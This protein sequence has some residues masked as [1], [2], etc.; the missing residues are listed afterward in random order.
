VTVDIQYEFGLVKFLLNR[1]GTIPSPALLN[2]NHERLVA[3]LEALEERIG[4]PVVRFKTG[5]SKENLAR[6]F[7]DEA[8]ATGRPGLVL[9]GKAQERTSVWRVGMSTPIGP[10]V[11]IRTGPPPLPDPPSVR[12]F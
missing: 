8:A 2:R 6:P 3:E 5:E 4:V 12:V 11:I 1:G 9:I 7:Q 10:T